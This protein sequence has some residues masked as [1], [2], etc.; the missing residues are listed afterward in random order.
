MASRPISDPA[1]DTTVRLEG[2]VGSVRLAARWTVHQRLERA[3]ELERRI[4][5]EIAGGVPIVLDATDLVAVDTA[6]ALVLSQ[7]ADGLRQGGREVRISGL[8]DAQQSL[9]EM[10]AA[11]EHEPPAPPRVAL[12][13][14]R[15]AASSLRVADD[16]ISFL[17]FL[18]HVFVTSVGALI[19]PRQ[20]R[21]RLVLRNLQTAGADALPI[22]GLLSFLIGIV[23]AYQGAFQLHRFGADVF[24]VDLVGLSLLRELAPLMTAIIVAGRTGS[25]YAAQIGTMRVTEEVDALR[26]M[27]LSPVDV[28]VRPKVFALLIALPL[29]TVFADIVGVLGG[30]LMTSVS[31][32]IG[33]TFFLAQF[34]RVVPL[35]SFL[36]GVGKAPVFALVIASVGCWQGFQASDS[37]ESVGARTTLSVVHSVFLIIVLDAAFSIVFSIVGI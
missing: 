37:A 13:R 23:I 18:G 10:V 17:S 2:D 28:L 30:L 34:P 20:I 6:G 5:A 21:G 27:G 33:P 3:G 24:I 35:E 22:I 1:A 11:H 8:T 9:F 16:A 26:V 19:R 32:D 14:E 7:L 12:A 31:T 25:A 15:A 29:L 4:L 36:V